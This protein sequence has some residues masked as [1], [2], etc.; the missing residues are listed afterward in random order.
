MGGEGIGAWRLAVLV[1]TVGAAGVAG[2][3]TGAAA[4][5][6]RLGL[7]R[8]RCDPLTQ[9]KLL[10][11]G[12]ALPTLPLPPTKPRANR[13]PSPWHRSLPSRND[14]RESLHA[15]SPS[16]IVNPDHIVTIGVSV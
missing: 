13:P 12:G 9:P 15:T 1:A 6:R 10:R 3:R 14:L 8:T 11:H 4:I 7:N 16:Q 5:D 2:D